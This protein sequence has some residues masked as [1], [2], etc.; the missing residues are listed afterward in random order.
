MDIENNRLISCRDQVVEIR[1]SGVLFLYQKGRAQRQFEHFTGQLKI[2]R[3]S[4]SNFRNNIKL[5]SDFAKKNGLPYV[6]IIYPAKPIVFEK[7]L[8]SAGVNVS[9]IVEKEHLM[10]EV[11][12]PLSHMNEVDHYEKQGSH[13][14]D[15]GYFTILQMALRKMAIEIPILKPVTEKKLLVRDLARMKGYSEPVEEVLI[16]GFEGL[17]PYKKF[18]SISDALD[19]NSGHI[20]YYFNGNSAVRQ[21]LLLFGDSFFRGSMRVLS[22]IFEEVIY[23]SCPYV[24]PD[25]ARNLNPDV[26]WTGNAERYLTNVPDGSINPPYFLNY[27]SSRFHPER[28]KPDVKAVFNLLFSGKSNPDYLE[29]KKNLTVTIPKHKLKTENLSEIKIEDI[30]G[31]ADVDT[32]RDLA[33]QLEEKDLECATH[34]MN[35]A[36]QVR[37]EGLLIQDKLKVYRQNAT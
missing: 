22:F 9:S 31:D 33:I 32:C 35:L 6:H 5:S 19:G 25:I 4:V 3:K 20:E 14:S 17:V 13:N 28:I 29:W 11:I 26:I 34:L 21:R 24:K 30:K 37:P 1:E 10:E 23:I 16:V 18:F 12:Y 2:N 8:R 7:S 27:F 15:L 36:H